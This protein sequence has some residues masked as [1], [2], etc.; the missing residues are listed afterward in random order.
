[1]KKIIWAALFTL[2]LANTAQAQNQIGALT[3]V[4]SGVTDCVST[5]CTNLQTGERQ[6]TISI[7]VTGTWSATLSFEFSRDGGTT[8]RALAATNAV[9]YAGTTSTTANGSWY[10][11]SV[12][13]T[14]VRVRVTA[15]TSGTANVVVRATS[16]GSVVATNFNPIA[17]TDVAVINTAAS[18]NVELVPLVAGKTVYVCS[19]YV[20]AEGAVDVRLVY[21]TGTACATGET[22]VTGTYALSTTAFVNRGSGIGLVTRGIV[23]NAL[24]VETSGAV[25]INGEVTYTQF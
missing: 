2:A 7:D 8:W 24:C 17:C 22:S 6:N 25:Q 5:N 12:N 14:H 10:I 13:F 3:A 18:G 20:I 23:S 4:S 16:N 15:F 1:M 19:Y 9:T 21:G 11:A